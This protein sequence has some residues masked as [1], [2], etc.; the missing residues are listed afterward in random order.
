MLLQEHKI[1]DSLVSFGATSGETFIAELSVP[2]KII[3]LTIFSCSGR[4]R[5]RE[6][7]IALM[8]MSRTTLAVNELKKKIFHLLSF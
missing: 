6:S 5:M 2:S 4:Q 1:L 3:Y 8:Q 7:S